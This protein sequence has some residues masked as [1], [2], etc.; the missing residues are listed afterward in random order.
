[1]SMSVETETITK[2]LFT[3]DEYMRMWEVGI[4]PED[5]RFELIRGEIIEMPPPGPQHSSRVNRLNRLFT[6]RFGDVI[7]ASIQN[8][9][10]IDR[11]SLPIP[12][13]TLLKPRDDFYGEAHPKPDDVFLV[14]EVSHTTVSYDGKTKSPMYAEAGIVEYWQLDVKKEVLFVR[15]NPVDGEYRNVQVL[16]RGE[17]VCPQ[18]LSTATFTVD[19]MLG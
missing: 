1:M 12:D 15:T 5:G 16:H 3:V 18:K 8:A 11:Y 19:E 10:T 9:L 7:I 4:L 14:V 6:S 2:K 13:V 17:T